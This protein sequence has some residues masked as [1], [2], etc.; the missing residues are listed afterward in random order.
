MPSVLLVDDEEMTLDAHRAM[1]ESADDITVIATARDGL[2]AIESY[3][4]LQPDVVVMDLHM[5]GMTGAEATAQIVEEFPEAT[6]LVMT[7]FGTVDWVAP[8]L[9]AGAAGYLLKTETADVIQRGI[10]QAH[11]GEFPIDASVARLLAA[12]AARVPQSPIRLT[13]RELDILECLGEGMRNEDIQN[14]LFLSLSTVKGY[15]SQ[16]M[17]KLEATNRVQVVVRAF[18]LGILPRDKK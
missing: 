13:D 17:T 9:Q 16:L 4:R 15:V 18:Q 8:A 12:R 11:Q 5:R 7:S 10:R 1:L 3:R 6:V 14:H 2:G